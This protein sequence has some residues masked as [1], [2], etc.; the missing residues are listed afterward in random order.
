MAG[1]ALTASLI[2]AFGVPAARAAHTNA[3]HAHAAGWPDQVTACGVERW[4]VKTGIDPDA[5]LVTLKVVVP[6]T[7]VHMRS[8]PAPAYLPLRSQ[9]PRVRVHVAAVPTPTP[10]PGRS[11]PP[12]IYP[13]PVT[14]HL[15]PSSPEPAPEMFWGREYY[16]YSQGFSLT[17]GIVDV[18]VT[19]LRTRAS[20]RRYVHQFPVHNGHHPA[21]ALGPDELISDG[22]YADR[23][24]YQGFQYVLQMTYRNLVITASYNGYDAHMRSILAAEAIALIT[25]KAAQEL[26]RIRAY[27]RS[28]THDR[29][30][31]W[32]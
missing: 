15:P 22:M 31:A 24:S 30:P 9:R 28:H 23:P 21:H 2:L 13:P 26:V 8:L 29:W 16:S 27:A 3:H 17:H 6:T 12:L 7:I 4:A 25:D 14:F 20:A 19:V 1:Y 11:A 18:T 10:R 5:R 32:A